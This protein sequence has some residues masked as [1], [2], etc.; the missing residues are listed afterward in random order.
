MSRREFLTDSDDATVALGRRL[1]AEVRAP[2]LILMYGDMGAG[3][4]TFAKG[5]IS[6][7]GAAKEEEVTSPTFTLVHQFNGAVPVFHVDLYR[8]DAGRDMDTLGLDD[9][10]DR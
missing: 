7:L 4:T 6:G 10:W 8:I 2:L 1:A 5:L 3:K 9:I